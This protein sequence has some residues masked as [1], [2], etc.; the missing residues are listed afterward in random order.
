MW[1]MPFWD[2]SFQ[3]ETHHGSVDHHIPHFGWGTRAGEEREGLGDRACSGEEDWQ[4]G[5]GVWV[6]GEAIQGS[7]EGAGDR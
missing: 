7:F 1:K 6:L 3:C 4:L 5:W 2:G